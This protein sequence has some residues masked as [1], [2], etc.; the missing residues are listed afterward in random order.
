MDIRSLKYFEEIAKKKSYTKAAN[1]LYISQP[2][3]SKTIKK[4]EAELGI[5]LFDR[6]GN[7][8]MLTGEGQ[9]LLERI[10]P[11]LQ[12][13]EEIFET[14]QDSPSLKKGSVSIGI[15]PIAGALYFPGIL[16]HFQ[17]LYPGINV[18]MSE[19]GGK[20][21]CEAVLAGDLDVGIAASPFLSDQFDI[22]PLLRE[23]AVLCVHQLHPL[24]VLDRANLA[25][26]AEE[27]FVLLSE[28]FSLHRQFMN[29]TIE[30]GFKPKVTFVSSQW[31]FLLKLVAQGRG[32][33]VMPKPLLETWHWPEI[34]FLEL[35][36][37][38]SWDLCTFTKRNRY[39]TYA[40]RAMMKVIQD[41]FS[42]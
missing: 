16:A 31:D 20:A 26:L 39:L 28:E 18:R 1:D 24:A 2:G 40:A 37:L 6:C 34:R 27:N 41:H 33:T 4:M 21:V 5:A 13:F 29:H 14:L 7:K 15:P 9:L 8:L 32:I 10:Q 38:L 3:L 22:Q 30:A 36:P 19:F 11:L 42:L 12:E 17:E 23:Q 25:E 35:N